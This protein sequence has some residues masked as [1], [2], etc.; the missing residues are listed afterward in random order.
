[1][2]FWMLVVAGIAFVLVGVTQVVNS[3]A[4]RHRAQHVPGVVVGMTVSV[5][6]RYST[7][8]YHTVLEFTTSEGQ[9]VRTTMQVGSR[10]APAK[11]RLLTS[12]SRSSH[13]CCNS[14]TNAAI[15]VSALGWAAILRKVDRM[16]PSDRALTMT[17]VVL[18]RPVVSARTA[19]GPG[20]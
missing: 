2:D 15:A 20:H 16:V 13:A 10:P 11:W 1:M 5:S 12:A 9:H 19:S 17:D 18:S 6:G 7:S 8:L 3:Y 14:L 4:F